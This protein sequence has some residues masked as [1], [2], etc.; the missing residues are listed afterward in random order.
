[1]RNSSIL[2]AVLRETMKQSGKVFRW[3]MLVVLSWAA[4]GSA[5]TA[6]NDQML[7][8]RESDLRDR[9][10]AMLEGVDDVPL[11]LIVEVFSGH[12]V[13]PWNGEEGEALES[14]STAVLAAINAEGLRASRVNE[15]GN[16]VEAFVEEAL[17]EH[18]FQAGRPAG[19]S[20]KV[21]SAGYPD[22]EAVRG[23]HV[24]YIEVKSY[25]TTTA[26]STQ[27]TFYVSPSADFKVTRDACHLLIAV[28][29]AKESDAYVARSVKWV[30]LSGLKCDL[31]YELN[32]SNRDLYG[33]K[34]GLVIIEISE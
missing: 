24:F 13:I 18:G 17:K 21:H 6:E 22:L 10:S 1:M 23:D 8:A 20:G 11:P 29:L 27:R 5:Q 3:M 28:E 34:A 4:A 15:A 33:P 32:A 26:D 7:A 9:L 14:V 12:K 30:D 31:K 2:R 25:N 16:K 19:P